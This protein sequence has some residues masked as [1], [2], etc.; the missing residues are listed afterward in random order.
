[1]GKGSRKLK[2]V[3]HT[4]KLKGMRRSVSKGRSWK[5]KKKSTG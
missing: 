3:K 4:K 1:L 5:K 2:D